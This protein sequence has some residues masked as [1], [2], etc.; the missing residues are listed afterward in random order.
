MFRVSPSL[1]SLIP[2][3]TAGRA[4]AMLHRRPWP[5]ASGCGTQAPRPDAKKAA[6]EAG[7]RRAADASVPE[8]GKNRT[9]RV[10][11]A[12]DLQFAFKAAA[13][14]FQANH[15]NCTVEIVFGS[16]GNLF[17]QLTNKAPFDMFLSADISYPRAAGRGRTGLRQIPNSCTALADRGVGAG[18]FTARSGKARHP[19]RW[20][21]RRSKKSPSPTRSMLPTAASAEAAMQKLG[22]YDEAQDRL[23][24]GE[25]ISQAA[26]FVESGAADMGSLPCRWPWPRR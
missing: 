6:A 3:I 2:A 11:A 15:R 16:S 18:L 24:L 13:A 10:A 19:R 9:V 17:A 7:T 14:Q 25:N 12:S 20:S 1:R 8:S 23:V 4:L 22:V 21:I 26:Q 5:A